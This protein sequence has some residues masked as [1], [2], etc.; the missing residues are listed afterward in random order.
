MIGG[1]AMRV[2]QLAGI[3]VTAIVVLGVDLDV[4]WATMLGVFCG[5]L[6]TYLVTTIEMRR[7]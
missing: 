1:I 5:A 7:R 2:A 3:A 4:R 6:T